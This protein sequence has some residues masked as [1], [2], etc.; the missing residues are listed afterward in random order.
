MNNQDLAKQ[1][2][3]Q[4]GGE[5]NVISLVHCATRLRFKL[6]D[7]SRANKAA[8]E[9]MEGVITVV[10]SAGQLQVVI[11]NNV[12]QVYAQIMKDTNLEDAERKGGN[13]ERSNS[14]VLDKAIDLISGIFSPLL[15]AFAGA[16]LLKGLL[17]LF[18][19]LSWLD[20][21][22][23]TY[24]ILNA[25]AD[26]TFYFLPILLGFTSARKFQANPF[27][28]VAIAGALVYPSILDAFN[29]AQQIAFL[30]I[31]VTLI[32]YTSSVIP[33]LLAV[34]IQS[35]VE[36]LL[37]S[38]IHESVRNIFVPMLALVIVVPL[39]FLIFGPVGN[40]ISQAVAS[41]YTWVYNLS[42]LIAGIIAGAFWQVFVIF[43]VH[44]GF[45]PIMLNNLTT[46]GY[47][48]MMPMLAAAVLAQAGAGL[49][50]FLKSKNKQTKALAGSTTIAGVF[51]ITEP[52]VY[53][54]TLKF[55]KPFIYAC[56]SGAVGGAIIGAGG[57]RGFGF[58]FPSL[59]AIP[60]YIGSGFTTTMIG[61]TVA[62][63]LAIVLV[64]ILG[65]KEETE[66]N[67]A[68]SGNALG[69]AAP[70]PGTESLVDK[71][72]IVSPLNG[73]IMPLELLPDEA[74]ASGAMGKGIVIEPSSGR[75]TSPVSGTVTT[76]FPTG[77]AIG[78]TSDEGVEL[79]I[80]VGVNTV[81]LKGQFFDKKVKEGDRVKQGDLL[82]DFDVEQIRAAGFVTATPII[83]TNSAS[84]LDVLKTD[85]SEAKHNDYLL[86][87]VNHSLKEDHVYE[88]K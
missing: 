33:I 52:L 68:A 88:D 82:L 47:D 86:T 16:G 53:G 49:G 21:A 78:I 7:K 75:L 25:A 60:T 71:E 38:I 41:G 44:W 10:E 14:S 26:S 32:N 85:K 20:A 76:V 13:T 23:G 45:I 22:N 81:K 9:K 43:G 34:W 27:V 61:I 42:P 15:G 87:I 57:G 66:E 59:L 70:L 11:G 5:S 39:T 24:M 84:Y 79:L 80:H 40:T 48:T 74:I 54:I 18:V 37:R 8:L 58:A 56:I 62:F 50:V 6:K 69:N 77:H 83:V 63:I 36:K 30:G 31:P 28:A 3:T 51:G 35:Y 29:N 55:K 64:L 17:A 2:I 46:V 67:T 19:Q 72:V 12:G 1:I 73:K 4:V 65:F